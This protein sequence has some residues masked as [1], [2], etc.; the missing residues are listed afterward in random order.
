[1]L[2]KA[3]REILLPKFVCVSVVGEGGLCGIVYAQI[4]L[5]EGSDVGARVWEVD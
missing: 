2:K 1:M 3:E 4:V 5:C